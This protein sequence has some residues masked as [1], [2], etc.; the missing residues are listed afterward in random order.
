MQYFDG[1]RTTDVQSINLEGYGVKRKPGLTRQLSLREEFICIVYRQDINLKNTVFWFGVSSS[2]FSRNFT[3]WINF[4]SMELELLCKNAGPDED[5]LAS[6]LNQ[7]PNLIV[8][9]D[10]FSETLFSVECH[11]QTHGIHKHY[12]TITFLVGIHPSWAMTYISK[13]YPGKSSWFSYTRTKGYGRHGV[14]D[15]KLRISLVVS[16]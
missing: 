5:G 9:L 11:K 16:N 7:F 14:Y 13:A 4:S 3:L 8:I 6:C 2:Q 10:L 12:S 15:W 1:E